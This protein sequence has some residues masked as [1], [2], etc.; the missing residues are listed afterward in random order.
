MKPVCL[1]LLFFCSIIPWLHA[2]SILQIDTTQLA[3]N[4][5]LAFEG[6]VVSSRSEHIPGGNIYTYIDF[7]IIDVVIGIAEPGTII[8]LRFTGGEVGDLKLDVGADIPALGE[9]GIYFVEVLNGRLTN[10]LLGWSQGQFRIQQDGSLLAGNNQ[11]VVGITV[12]SSASRG[13][14]SGVAQGIITA[15]PDEI[16]ARSL[17][18]KNTRPVS[19]DEFKKLIKGFRQ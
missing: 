6:E 3:N 8:S 5:E 16:P 13:M 14:S 15:P 18:H 2:S 1:L 19:V 10:P 17:Q 9:R 4:A 7:L 11:R 12:D